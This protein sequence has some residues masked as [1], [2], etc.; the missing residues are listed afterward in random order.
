MTSFIETLK[1]PTLRQE[2]SLALNGKG[3][4]RKFKD[5]LI[6]YPKERKR[7]HGHNAKA[8]KSEIREWLHSV[9]VKPIS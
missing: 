2:L 5:I 7:W 1:D 4:F 8:I 3:A 6:N 9:G